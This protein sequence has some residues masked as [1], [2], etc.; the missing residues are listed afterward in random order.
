ML[1]VGQRMMVLTSACLGPDW[2][3]CTRLRCCLPHS[4]LFLLKL[5]PPMLSLL[6]TQ[7]FVFFSTTAWAST[8]VNTTTLD[9]ALILLLLSCSLLFFR[10]RWE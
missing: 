6:F 7:M 10:Q 1:L 8:T 2:S 9:L 3:H 4:I 5:W